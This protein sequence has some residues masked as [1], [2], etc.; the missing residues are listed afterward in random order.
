M[1]AMYLSRSAVVGSPRLGMPS[2]TALAWIFWPSGRRNTWTMVR[3]ISRWAVDA[4]KP[5]EW[6]LCFCK[7]LIIQELYSAKFHGP[8][9]GLPCPEPEISTELHQGAAASGPVESGFGAKHYGV[10]RYVVVR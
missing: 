3:E 9:P 7:V 6:R 2:M 5:R 1:N 10:N 8:T 4:K